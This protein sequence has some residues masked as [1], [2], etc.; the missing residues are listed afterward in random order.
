ML[1]QATCLA[2]SGTACCLRQPRTIGPKRGCDRGGLG[3]GDGG[4]VGGSDTAGGHCQV[5]LRP[6]A[7]QL[8]LAR[9]K[10]RNAPGKG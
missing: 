2:R 5:V 4:D 9:I 7:A 1:S 8:S 10:R 6:R 3:C